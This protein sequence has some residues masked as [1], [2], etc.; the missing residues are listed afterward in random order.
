MVINMIVDYKIQTRTSPLLLAQ[1]WAQDPNKPRP[2]KVERLPFRLFEMGSQTPT[3]PH[4]WS[5]EASIEES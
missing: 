3:K 1:K 4:P 5:V 2:G